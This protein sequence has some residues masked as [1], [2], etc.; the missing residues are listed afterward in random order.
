MGGAGPC[1][2]IPNP[3]PTEW[4]REAG[5]STVGSNTSG[6]PQ[7][8]YY[9]VNSSQSSVSIAPMPY[10]GLGEGGNTRE[11][12]QGG[13]TSPAELGL[14]ISPEGLGPGRTQRGNVQV[15]FS[16]QMGAWVVCCA[17]GLMQQSRAFPVAALGFEGAKKA[18]QQYATHCRKAHGLFVGDAESTL[19][20]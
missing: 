20:G 10:V 6:D 1:G 8:P 4:V 14:I 12:S 9:M 13:P 19:I 16:P 11:P 17:S 18:A 15:T 5:S 7:Q 2:L 3:I